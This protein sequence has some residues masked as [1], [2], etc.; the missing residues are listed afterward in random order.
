MDVMW[1]RISR[2]PDDPGQTFGHVDRGGILV[3]LNRDTYWQA[4]FVIAKGEADRIRERGLEEFREQIGWLEPFLR[5][6]LE[7]VRDW[8]DVSVLTVTVDRLERW[9]RPGILCIG[10][11]A[12]AM[13]PIGGVGINL[14]IQDAVAAANILGPILVRRAP[15]ELELR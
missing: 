9:S 13:S 6:R 15:S 8:K 2:R 10:D 5:S 3:L 14:A 11:A 1:M 12:H 4:A 7:E